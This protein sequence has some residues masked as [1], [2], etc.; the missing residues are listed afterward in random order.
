MAPGASPAIEGRRMVLTLV[1]A[2]KTLWEK[3]L[4]WVTSP[5]CWRLSSKV[6]DAPA[7]LAPSHEGERGFAVVLPGSL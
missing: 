1:S 4:R 3:G 6:L 5:V 2:D 7:Q